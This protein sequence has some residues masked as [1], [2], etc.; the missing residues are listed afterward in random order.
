MENNFVPCYN[1]GKESI[2]FMIKIP[3]I[4]NWET[5]SITVFTNTMHGARMD[6]EKA[7]FC[8]HSILQFHCVIVHSTRV[9]YCPQVALVC[10]KFILIGLVQECRLCSVTTCWR[11]ELGEILAQSNGVVNECCGIYQLS[12]RIVTTPV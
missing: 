9:V 10:R 11:A 6:R 8:H 3:Y 1:L 5:N 2:V 12:V 4:Y 7:F